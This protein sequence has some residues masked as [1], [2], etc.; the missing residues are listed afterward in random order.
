[1]RVCTPDEAA[2]LV[3]PRDSL[4]LPLGPGQPRAFLGALGRR[5]DWEDLRVFAALLMDLFP[6]FARPGVHLLSGFFGPAERALRAAGHS[7]AFVP[8]DFRSFVR[9]ARRLAPRVV[10]TNATPPDANGRMSLSLHA[11][12]TVDEI[13]RAGRDP[14]RLLVVETSPHLPRTRGVGDHDHGVAVGEVDVLIEGDME[15]PVLEERE[16]DAAE[17]TIAELIAGY[18]PDGA[19]LQTGIGAIPDQVVRGLARGPG[20]DYGIHSEMFTTGLMHLHQAGRVTN[21]KGIYDGVSVATFALGSRS[22]YDWL[23]GQEAVGFLPV[24]L[25][26][27]PALIARNRRM[28]A[29]NGALSID[30]AGQV[31]A[32]TV[33]GAQYSGIGGHEDFVGGGGRAEEGRSL[34]CLP[35]TVSLAG[36]VH[37]RI[38]AELEPGAIVTTPRHQLDVVVTEYGCA[39]VSGVSAEER[40]LALAR[41]AHPAFRDEL[42]ARARE[43]ARGRTPAT[44][45][46]LA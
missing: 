12:A 42:L 31:V 45:S 32:D 10:A 7:V 24:Q 43:G 8:A 34:V 6:L 14:E 9:L 37:S 4:A 44:G 5:D 33:A 23:D 38:V 36:A 46:G 21:R 28:R 17:R 39:E 2:A 18:L 11:G 13:H 15:P 20:G 27:D 29:I 26:N 16:P 35:S 30:L 40:A 41:I 3:R 19:T 25:V 22:L 1:M